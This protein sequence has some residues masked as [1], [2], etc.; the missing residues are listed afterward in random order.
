VSIPDLDSVLRAARPSSWASRPG[1]AW[2]DPLDLKTFPV[3]KAYRF[4]FEIARLR[5]H[6]TLF[7]LFD[8]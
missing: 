8:K 5:I 6:P 2:P 3:K 4:P 1:A 7:S